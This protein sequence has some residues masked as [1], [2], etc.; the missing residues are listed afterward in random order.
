MYNWVRFVLN[1]PKRLAIKS[2][3]KANAPDRIPLSG[4]QRLQQRDYFVTHLGT[5]ES[6]QGFL[7][8]HISRNGVVGAWWSQKDRSGLPASIPNRFLLKPP[9]HIKHYFREI[10]IDYRSSTLF[11]LA[12]ICK[13]SRI[14]LAYLRFVQWK[15][16]RRAFVR[17][18]RYEVLRTI[19]DRTMADSSYSTSPIFY[20][21]ERFGD[22]CIPHPANNELESYYRFV[23]DALVDSGELQM[24]DLS[25]TLTPRAISTLAELEDNDRRHNDSVRLQRVLTW[26]TA[27]LVVVG[28]LQAAL[29]VLFSS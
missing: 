2:A 6:E 7:V 19:Y 5:G 27:A 14:R 28:L 25:Y 20:M 29:S 16:N 12:T 1:S 22:R 11:F 15:Y 21:V 24:N 10:E 8:K 13:W 17:D 9:L 4:W 26:L 3:L 18:E 23:L